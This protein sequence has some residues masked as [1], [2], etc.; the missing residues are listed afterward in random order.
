MAP[1]ARQFEFTFHEGAA[2]LEA[3][4]GKPSAALETLA[5]ACDSGASYETAVLNIRRKLRIIRIPERELDAVHRRINSFLFPVDLMMG[6]HAHGYVARRSTLSNAT[7]HVGAKF[8]QK[9]DIKNFFASIALE[10]IIS[11]LRQIGLGHEAAALLGRLVTCSGELPLGART[12]PRISNLVLAEFDQV[13]STVADDF[14]LVYTRYADDLSFSGQSHFDVSQFVERE[15]SS[16]GYELNEAK[17]KMFRHG[18]PMFV[19]GLAISDERL[20]RVRK[21][22]KARLRKEFYFVEKFGL[23][24]HAEVLDEDMH[25]AGARIMGH[26]HYVRAIEPEFAAKLASSFPIAFQTLIPER[27]DDRIA[28]V[29]R[30]REEFLLDVTSRPAQHLPLYI[31]NTP[32]TTSA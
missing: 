13:I 7:P 15:L 16:R 19:T 14:G 25:Q 12:S 8:L 1:L 32:L 20:A 4:L 18:Q 11:A 6:P 29:Q 26:Y 21:R 10:Q 3:A 17:S 27:H 9:F 5:A 24:G 30:K 28:R 2:S 31:P 23:D 22:V